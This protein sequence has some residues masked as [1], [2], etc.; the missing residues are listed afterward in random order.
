MID[1]LSTITSPDS[2]GISWTID[3]KKVVFPV[4]FGATIHVIDPVFNVS[5]KLF[6]MFLLFNATQILVIS[7]ELF[8]FFLFLL[9]I[10]Y[11]DYINIKLKKEKGCFLN[12]YL[13]V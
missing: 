10:S 1:V 13:V 6:K 2:S 3:L 11:I 8:N 9:E 12:N 7:I 5:D 4:P